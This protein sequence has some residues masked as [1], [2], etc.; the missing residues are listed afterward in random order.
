MDG[1]NDPPGPSTPPSPIE[2]AVESRPV[3]QVEEPRPERQVEAPRPARQAR[4]PSHDEAP[5]GPRTRSKGP[6]PRGLPPFGGPPLPRRGS[7]PE[8][9]SI[10]TTPPKRVT[11]PPGGQP[12]PVRRPQGSV[13]RSLPAD[14][15]L[16]EQGDAPGPRRSQRTAVKYRNLLG[17]K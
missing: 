12:L 2:R 3:R 15:P 5:Q 14:I 11:E 10:R 8:R 6:P 17:P 13:A 4:E 1:L 7:S 9:R 16:N